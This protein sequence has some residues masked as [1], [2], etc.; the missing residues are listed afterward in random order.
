M[1]IERKNNGGYTLVEMIIVIAIIAILSGGAA[2]TIS[3]IRTSQATSAMERFDDEIS[4]LQMRTNSQNGNSAIK[5]AKSA[6]K[7][8]NYEIYYGTCDKAGNFKADNATKP[9]A[10]LENVTIWYDGTYDASASQTVLDSQVIR[11]RK[12]DGEVLSGDGEYKFI[13]YNSNGSVGRV[14]IN[15]YTGSHTYGAN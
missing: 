5:V 15:K 13:K 11:I 2:I 8:R 9:D 6:D 4:A 3:A 12:S 10:I 14:T 7:D 1:I